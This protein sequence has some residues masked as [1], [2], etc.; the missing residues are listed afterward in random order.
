MYTSDEN[1]KQLDKFTAKELKKM[2]EQISQLSK[3]GSIEIFKI[4][5]QNDEKYSENNNGILFDMTKLSD[6]TLQ[7]INNFL[8][9]NKENQ[10]KLD[11]E[12]SHRET[13]KNDI[14]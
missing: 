6:K 11:L 10:K 5:R 9:Y 13:L 7:I 14:E 1:I 4:I 8:I 3:E 2:R 12:E